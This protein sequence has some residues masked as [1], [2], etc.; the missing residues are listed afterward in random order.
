M[1]ASGGHRNEPVEGMMSDAEIGALRV[2]LAS[3]P[4]SDD[5]RQR[6]EDIDARSLQYG[7]APDVAV[8]PVSANG[9]RPNGH[10][11]R[12]PIAMPR[13]FFCMAAAL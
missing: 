1:S 5:Y 13:S 2:K 11:R 10:R 9:V 8:E 12:K 6:R 4:R 3:I 7:L